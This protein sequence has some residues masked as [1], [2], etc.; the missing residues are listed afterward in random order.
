M[1]LYFCGKYVL[2]G[3]ISA[4]DSRFLSCAFLS[5]FEDIIKTVPRVPTIEHVVR[6]EITIHG[7]EDC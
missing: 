3:D 5:V 2:Q 1:Y 7:I 4:K 6:Y